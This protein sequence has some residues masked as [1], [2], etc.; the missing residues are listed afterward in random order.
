[1]TRPVPAELPH[2]LAP[3][4]DH[5]AEIVLALRARVLAQVPNAHEIVWDATNTVSLVYAPSSRWQDGIV[6]IPAYA[7]HANLGFN[8]GA[9]LDDPDRRLVGTG[10]RIR[11]VTFRTVDEVGA[12]W[13]DD[14][15]RAALRQAGLDPDIG[16]GGTTLRTSTGPKRRPGSAE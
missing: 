4:P 14:Y 9:G 3:F 16:D 15:L 11:H 12:P 8:D 6:H 7:Q 2:L 5:V 13:I 1:V 10:T